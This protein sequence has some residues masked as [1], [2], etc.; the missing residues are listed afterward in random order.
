[1]KDENKGSK[2]V[3]DDYKV[4][5]LDELNE[6]DENFTIETEKDYFNELESADSEELPEYDSQ[7][8]KIIKEDKK[9]VEA[10]K[11]EKQDAKLDNNL[12]SITDNASKKSASE[13]NVK[14]E[15]RFKP[16]RLSNQNAK[17]DETKRID[18]VKVDEDGVPLLNQFDMDQIKES[19][20]VPKFTIRK[21]SLSKVF[22]IIVG[23]I[24]TLF[25][26]FQA[27]NDVVKVS[28]HVMYGEHESMAMG[29][30]F[31]GIII[32]ILA[33]YKEIMKAMGL[34]NLTASLDDTNSSMPKS[35]RNA[36][37]KKKTKK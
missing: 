6:F 9:K 12:D 28:D 36:D 18:N 34:N 31:L 15:K 17:K 29:L 21:I 13:E 24:V 22:M 11:E 8:G 2:G 27:M 37:D 23:V 5:P 7:K 10:N 16:K 1:M 20:F 19:G 32:I 14:T 4:D 25:G 30:I 35:R 3:K 26:L 33:F